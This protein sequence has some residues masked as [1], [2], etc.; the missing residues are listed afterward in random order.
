ML[1]TQLHD[2]CFLFSFNINIRFDINWNV[3]LYAQ[4][5]SAYNFKHARLEGRR[6]TTEE[7]I[8]DGI[9]CTVGVNEPVWE[10]KPG[11]HRLS[12]IRV[13]KRPEDSA[14]KQN[15]QLWQRTVK[16]NKTQQLIHWE[17]DSRKRTTPTLDK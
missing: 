4:Q 11:V 17:S 14:G 7:I 2:I 9:C 16:G 1:E 6:L 10:G 12:V 3:T 8:D 5:S 15:S 13:L